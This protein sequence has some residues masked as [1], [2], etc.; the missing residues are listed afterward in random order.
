MSPVTE[1]SVPRMRWCRAAIGDWRASGPPLAAAA[2]GAA[3][4]EEWNEWVQAGVE[5][6]P[7]RGVGCASARLRIRSGP[8][9]LPRLKQTGS[10]ASHRRV[11][12]G[13]PQS[14]RLGGQEAVCS[15]SR[16]HEGIGSGASLSSPSPSIASS[17]T[18]WK[19]C[20]F[21]YHE[22]ADASVRHRWKANLE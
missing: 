5:S 16:C 6:A 3:R 8:G 1:F 12:L 9:R 7:K 17:P 22:L 2:G 10:A 13:S 15:H 14:P 20:E 21:E 11:V 19:A 18:Q 4:T